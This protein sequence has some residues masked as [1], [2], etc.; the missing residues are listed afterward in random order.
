MPIRV[1][2]QIKAKS[3]FKSYNLLSTKST[4]FR[5]KTNLSYLMYSMINFIRRFHAHNGPLK[6]FNIIKA[7]NKTEGTVLMFTGYHQQRQ[8]QSTAA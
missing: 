3:F 5:Q 4:Y 8:E 6:C 2:L 7:G 1:A